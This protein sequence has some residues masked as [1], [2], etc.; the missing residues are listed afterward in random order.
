MLAGE[1]IDRAK[2]IRLAH[3]SIFIPSTAPSNQRN[4]LL[5]AKTEGA[6]H[7]HFPP[8][9]N[10]YGTTTTLQPKDKR[11]K[12]IALLF[13]FF[14]RARKWSILLVVSICKVP[15]KCVSHSYYYFRYLFNYR[16]AF[17]ACWNLNP[18]PP[19]TRTNICSLPRRVMITHSGIY[20]CYINARA[21]VVIRSPLHLLPICSAKYNIEINCITH[22][23]Y[24]TK[25]VYLSSIVNYLYTMY[26]IF[27]SSNLKKKGN[28]FLVTWSDRP[29][30]FVI[31]DWICV[32]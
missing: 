9:S 30:D 7:F 21:V 1:L 14:T 12:I 8:T 17:V 22:E 13:F 11:K 32:S 27:S 4:S 24:K 10:S 18:L 3:R 26:S 31:I 2:H 6:I 25:L 15:E 29:F 16:Y 23:I 5:R 28:W 20:E 19:Q